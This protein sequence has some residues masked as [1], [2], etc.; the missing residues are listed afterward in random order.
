MPLEQARQLSTRSFGEVRAAIRLVRRVQ[1]VRPWLAAAAGV[2]CLASAAGHVL[3]IRWLYLPVADGGGTHLLTA[4]IGLLLALS[5][6]SVRNGGRD[7]RLPRLLA[8]AALTL[9]ALRAT[10]LTLAPGPVPLGAWIDAW[11]G[12]GPLRP[13]IGTGPY[14][15]TALGAIAAAILIWPRASAGMAALLAAI[16]LCGTVLVAYS[17]ALS[18]GVGGMSPVTMLICL[19]LACA[20]ADR[21]LDPLALRVLISDGAVSTLLRRQLL[22]ALSGLWLGGLMLLQVRPGHWEDAAP[23]FVTAMLVLAAAGLISTMAILAQAENA[24]QRHLA[25]LERASVTDALTGLANRRASDL[26]ARRS[27][28][29]AVR[30]GTGLAV[31]LLD[32]DQFKAIN[33]RFGHAQGDRVLRE[34]GRLLPGWLRRSDLAVRWGGEEFL[35]IL[36]T[37]RLVGAMA[38]AE[39]VRHCFETRLRL[40]DGSAPVTVSLGCAE[41]LPGEETLEAALSRAD[42]ALYRAKQAG[43]NR[44]E[45]PLPPEGGAT[46][47]SETESEAEDESEVRVGRRAGDRAHHGADEGRV[48]E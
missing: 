43:R 31:V 23:L 34:V 8:S 40:P 28:A 3:D 6:L 48:G 22:L 17:Y 36:T 2:L 14:A 27:V 25:A 41:L 29:A 5:R 21:H 44:V 45:P 20:T 16:G 12:A 47:P 18:S 35:L 9:V 30:Q 24:R 13:E 15:A 39:R 42:A 33:D 37:T 11:I 46:R 10:E 32:I 4:L 1:R 7:G 19:L 26:F 38:L